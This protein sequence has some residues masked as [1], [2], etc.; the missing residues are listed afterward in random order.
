M[1]ISCISVKVAAVSTSVVITAGVRVTLGGFKIRP[2]RSI[3]SPTL[4]HSDLSRLCKSIGLFEQRSVPS[5]AA[6][7]EAIIDIH[8]LSL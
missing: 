3:C 2:K 5:G 7:P 4:S 6:C 8:D 1:L